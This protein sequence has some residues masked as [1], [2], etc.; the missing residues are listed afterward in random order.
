MTTTY[1][2]RIT[3]LV[4]DGR[5]G[6]GHR[7]RHRP[8]TAAPALANDVIAVDA[9]TTVPVAAATVPTAVASRPGTIVVTHHGGRSVTLFAKGERIRRVLAPGSRPATFTGLTAG[10]VY[11]VAIGG[12]PIGAVV[13]LDAPSAAS[14]LTVRTTDTLG[15]VA[16]TWRHRPTTAT[17]GR[18]IRY[19][20]RATSRTAPPVTTTV[21]GALTTRLTGLD[22]DA[23]YAFR[24]TPR[25]SAGT[26]RSTTATMSRTLAEASGRPASPPVA[27]AP[28]PAPVQP[29]AAA[30]V[31]SPTPPP[32]PPHRHPHL[33]LRPPPGRSGSAPTASPTPPASA[34]RRWP[35]RSTRRSRP[36]RTRT[37]PS[38]S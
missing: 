9:S 29:A 10:R 17:G 25:N 3:A 33:L 28:A 11:T 15:T 6:R 30:P 21:T 38:S 20:V 4:R 14:G 27:M 13:A 36:R 34:A 8:G 12:Q 18:A 1:L 23:V 16:L 2:S 7:H 19:D 22:A 31:T 32:A 5:A 35:T 26:G 37:T 24:V